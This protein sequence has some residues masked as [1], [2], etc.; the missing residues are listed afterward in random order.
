[1]EARPSEVYGFLRH[2][3]DAHTLGIDYIARL[4]RGSGHE[5]VIGDRA[6]VQA[7]ASI[8]REEAANRLLAWL[9]DTRVSRLGFS[10]R[11]EPELARD[12]FGRLFHLLHSRRC[13]ADQGGALRAI[14]FAGLPHA[15]ELVR[16]EHGDR[17][18][19]FEGDEAPE[20]TLRLLGIPPERIPVSLRLDSAYDD[21]RMRFATAFVESGGHDHVRP[22]DRARS[23]G[24]GSRT[25]RLV[26]RLEHGARH[27]LPPLIRAHVGPFC[28]PREL[29]VREFL[30]WTRD[31]A[32]GGLL[33][34]LS[35]GTSQLTQSAFGLDWDGRPNGGGVPI[36]SADEYR[37]IMEAARPMLVRTY[38]GTRDV[39]AL[40]RLHEETLNIAWH[41]LSFWWFSRIDGRGD[42]TV[43]ANLREH[44][45]AVRFIARSGK[46]LE[47][48]VPHHFAF[49]GADDVSYVLSAY[50]T[51]RTAKR[52]GI[53][54]FVLQNMLNTPKYTSGLS[55][56]A[57]SRAMLR[58]VR[59]LED[60][61]FKV[62]LQPRAGLDYFSPNPARA[63]AQLAASTA[64]MDDIEPG[65]PG[66][67][68]IIHVVSHSE[69]ISLADP[70]VIHDSIRI[71]R[72]ALDDY[73]GLKS[74]SGEHVF[75]L[76]PVVERK[77]AELLDGARA[78]LSVI[79]RE[80]P[81]P[82]CVDGLYRV[83]AAGFLPVPYL[84]E[85]TDEFRHAL[86]WKTGMHDGGVWVLDAKGQP[87]SPAER[88]EVA[89]S[90]LAVVRPPA[91]Q[92][93]V[94]GCSN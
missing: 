22:V 42:N 68:P 92:P 24:F 26:D 16:A 49:R 41:A 17:V 65:D 91:D 38:A 28:T 32:A 46:P 75:G 31:L 12:A 8:Q 44:L 10:F 77:T 25:E 66:S 81:D 72:G 80:I 82:Y 2:A 40:A 30:A 50:L 19:A 27:R 48:N 3:V 79:E 35:I 85:E 61:S 9:A 74:R 11:L 47:A 5:C 52:C 73:R 6:V 1:M 70:P 36:N 59:S 69:A 89:A 14:Y 45:E 4:I 18:I 83:F 54:T 71:V 33:D 58:F 64:L 21:E 57:K 37:E 86:E 84:W 13:F 29:A 43:H 78:V 67:P 51:A 88:A 62:V 93:A 94:A 76:D 7:V 55:D 60:A 53:R 20:Y 87:V 63:R 39:P 34:V 56:L 23:P 15:C 90:R